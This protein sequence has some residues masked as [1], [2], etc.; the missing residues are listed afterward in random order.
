MGRSWSAREAIHDAPRKVVLFHGAP[1]M[2]AHLHHEHVLDVQ[3]RGDAEQHG[4][5]AGRVGVGELGEIA[6]AEQ[7]LGI[8]PVAPDLRV[9]LERFHESEIDGIEHGVGE[10]GTTF[11]VERVHGAI[12][13]G[14]IAMILRDQH[15]RGFDLVGDVQRVF[16]EA[17]EKVGACLAAAQELIRGRRNR[18]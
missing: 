3:L 11:L 17:Q 6:G 14:K 18:R 12:E 8:G 2:R 16:V 10:I 7:H 13:R 4:G 9:A 15:R 5:D 1:R